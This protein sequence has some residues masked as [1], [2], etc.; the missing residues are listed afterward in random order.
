MTQT[1]GTAGT[2]ALCLHAGK[3]ETAPAAPDLSLRSSVFSFV[4]VNTQTSSDESFDP[5]KQG[6]AQPHSQLWPARDA[7]SL[8]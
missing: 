3:G 4:K 7:G 6:L 8:H 2:K 1:E 5:R